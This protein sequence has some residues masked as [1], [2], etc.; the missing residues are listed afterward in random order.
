MLT[1]A[2]PELP[3]RR[4]ALAAGHRLLALT[5]SLFAAAL[6]TGCQS[7]QPAQLPIQH[8]WDGYLPT[9][10][11]SLNPSASS[12]RH[13]EFARRDLA[14]GVHSNTIDT[15]SMYPA[16]PRPSLSYPR[17]Y[18]F[19]TSAEGYTYFRSEEE[20]RSTSHWRWGY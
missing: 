7:P 6:L 9:L 3:L 18:Y 8:Q 5:A 16:Q 20:V 19:P 12:V 13:D 2:R 17:R 14:L 4:P 11:V 10:A 1:S 15:P